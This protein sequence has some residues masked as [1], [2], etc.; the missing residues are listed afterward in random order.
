MV[1]NITDGSN[2]LYCDRDELRT[3]LVALGWVRSTDNPELTIMPTGDFT[4]VVNALYDRLTFI[5]A[6]AEGESYGGL[7]FTHTMADGRGWENNFV[8]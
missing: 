7:Y 1:I 5:D 8:W 4:T 3:A 2:S 6:P